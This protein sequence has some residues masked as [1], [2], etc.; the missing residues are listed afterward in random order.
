MPRRAGATAPGDPRSPS[1]LP[2]PSWPPATGS[3]R[4]A[5]PSPPVTTRGSSARRAGDA[6]GSASSRPALPPRAS[7]AGT[8]PRYQLATRLPRVASFSLHSSLFLLAGSVIPGSASLT[9]CDDGNGRS[10]CR[11][12]EHLEDHYRVAIDAVHHAPGSIAVV[13]TELMTAWADRRHRPRMGHCEQLTPLQP[14]EQNSCL[15]AGSR[16]QR[17]CLDLAPEP[18]ERFVQPSRQ[19]AQGYVRSD[20]D[21]SPDGGS[22]STGTFPMTSTIRSSTRSTPSTSCISSRALTTDHQSSPLTAP[23]R[24]QYCTAKTGSTA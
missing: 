16:R 5:W 3:N 6:P 12:A 14:A 11:L 19:G 1:G 21:S 13:D 18:D 15:D 2:P 8:R 23:S 24:Q 7:S 20:I 22:L 10:P 4:V 17:G 9:G